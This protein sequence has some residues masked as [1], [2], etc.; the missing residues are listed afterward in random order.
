MP[1]LIHSGKNNN[2]PVRHLEVDG[3]IIQRWF[4]KRVKDLLKILKKRYLLWKLENLVLP[5]LL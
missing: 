4:S 3:R 2:L 5:H 1:S